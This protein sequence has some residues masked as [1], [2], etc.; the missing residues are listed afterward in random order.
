MGKAGYCFVN[1]C[2]AVAFIE[3]LTAKEL[4]IDPIEFDEKV[5]SAKKRLE[6]EDSE[7]NLFGH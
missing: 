7:D 1:L 3:T 6:L 5:E 4:T 2:S